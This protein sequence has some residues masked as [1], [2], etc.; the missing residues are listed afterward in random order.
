MRRSAEVRD[1]LLRFYEVFSAE[2]LEGFA[3]IL[4][5]EDDDMKASW[6]LAPSLVS[7]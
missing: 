6:S 3:Q 4:A 2:D 5:Q 1:T 7:G